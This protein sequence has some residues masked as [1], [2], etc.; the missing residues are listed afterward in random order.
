MKKILLIAALALGALAGTA[1]DG[2]SQKGKLAAGLNIGYTPSLEKGMKVNNFGIAAKVQYGLTVA[3]RSELTVGYD[4]KD[5]EIGLFNTAVNMHYLF[6]VGE[7]LKIYPIVG[8]G[9]AHIS[10][11]LWGDMMDAFDE[12]GYYDEEEDVS[13]SKNKFLVN[14]GAG[15][16]L[17]LTERISV[18]LEVKYQYMKDFSRLPINLGV[19]Y[20]F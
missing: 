1:Q 2:T 20:K 18:G 12:L 5:K 10:F 19:T 13:L 17:S 16:E 7:K 11:G 4:F 8:V 3:L 14:A 9:Y 6:N 15:A